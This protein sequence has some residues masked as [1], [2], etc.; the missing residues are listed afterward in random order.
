MAVI[1]LNAR[2]EIPSGIFLAV[3]S[4]LLLTGI[5]SAVAVHDYFNWNRARWRLIHYAETELGARPASMDGG[6]EY[7]G[8]NN[9]ESEKNAA[10][11]I[12]KSWWWVVDD[13]FAVAFGLMPGY[14]SIRHVHVRGYLPTTPPVVYLLKRSD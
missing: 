12:N 14:S 2:G 10:R 3:F 1:S 6:F 13:R 9:F 5:L 11:K 7:N 4:C 8:F